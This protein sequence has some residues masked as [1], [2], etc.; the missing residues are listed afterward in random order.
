MAYSARAYRPGGQPAPH[1]TPEE[2]AALSHFHVQV[3][4]NKHYTEPIEPLHGVARG[5]T[6]DPASRPWTP[7]PRRGFSAGHGTASYPA[8]LQVARHPFAKVG[9]PHSEQ[10]PHDVRLSNITYLVI[11][12]Q[13]GRPGPKPRTLLFDMGA[14]VGT[15]PGGAGIAS[16]PR[17]RRGYSLGFSLR[18]QTGSH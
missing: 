17:L 14:S 3:G 7:R 13:C 8:R 4:E 6:V 11:H 5:A 9:C 1:P 10:H 16:T 15:S 12:N 18:L 2:K